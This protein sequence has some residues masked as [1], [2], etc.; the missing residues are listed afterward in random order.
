MVLS[1]PYDFKVDMWALGCVIY[2]LCS[3]QTPFC[4]KNL[5]ELGDNILKHQPPNLSTSI[6]LQLRRLIRSLLQKDP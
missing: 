5:M 4:G 3:L 1:K 2:N 6:S